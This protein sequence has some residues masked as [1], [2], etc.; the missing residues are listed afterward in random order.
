MPNQRASTRRRDVAV[1]VTLALL[2]A[3]ARWT[4][5]PRHGFFFDDAWVVV[6]A[7]SLTPGD[8]LVVGSA[9]PGFTT[10][11]HVVG[12][13]VGHS[14]WAMSAPSLIV[15]LL[16]PPI[17]YIGLRALHHSRVVSAVTAI[18]LLVNP[19]HV[20]YSGR[21]KS[22]VFD[23]AAVMLLAAIIPRMADRRWRWSTG[24]AWAAAMIVVAAGCTQPT[25]PA[26]VRITGDRNEAVPTTDVT[27]TTS[28]LP[29][30]TT[31]LYYGPDGPGADSGTTAE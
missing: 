14:T 15:G 25:K 21:P 20:A 24:L 1:A 6:G 7:I 13:L 8:L 9:H 26:E 11:L 17:V 18:P 22:Y 27:T 5:I 23:F 4:S 30:T 2:G 29:P 19:V 10:L 16:G 28:T 31:T 12:Q 3:W